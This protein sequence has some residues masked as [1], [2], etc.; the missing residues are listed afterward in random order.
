MSDFP[1]CIKD[2]KV[3]NSKIM[4]ISI[5]EYRCR[6]GCFGGGAAATS[7]PKQVALSK[8]R[9]SSLLILLPAAVLVLLLLSSGIEPNPGPQF[10]CKSCKT[11][12]QQLQNFYKHVSIHK[13]EATIFCPYI[14]CSGH[15]STIRSL[16]SH[17]SRDHKTL[18]RSVSI[19]T[20]QEVKCPILTCGILM[21]TRERYLKHMPHHLKEGISFSC[22]YPN[23]GVHVATLSSFRTHV[24]H[25]HPINGQETQGASCVSSSSS[26]CEASS[27]NDCGKQNLDSEPSTS[28]HDKNKQIQESNTKETAAFNDNNSEDVFYS[29]HAAKAQLAKFY[30]KLEAVHFLPISTVQVIADEIKLV[31]EMSHNFLE[32]CLRSELDSTGLHNSVV[33]EIVNKAFSSDPIYNI[34]HKRQD[35]EQL[36]TDHLRQKFWKKHYPFVQPKEI[37]LGRDVDGSKKLAHYVSIRESIEVMLRDPKIKKMVLDSFENKP[38]ST[39]LSDITD[40]TAF[41]EHKKQHHGGKCIFINLFQD[42]FDYNAFGPSIGVYKPLGFYFAI[43]NLKP[44]YRTK[45]DLI[46]MVYLIMEKH[47]KPSEKEELDDIDKLKEVLRPLIDELE[48]L[49]LNGISVDGEVVPVC[50]LFCQGDN[51]GQHVIGGFVGS[52][53]CQYCCRFCP[54]SLDEFRANPTLTKPLRT[55][56]GYDISVRKAKS[57]WFAFRDKCL[58]TVERRKL[59]RA[60]HAP[61]LERVRAPGTKVT[62]KRILAKSTFEKLRAHNFQGVKYR[63]SALNSEKLGFHVCN[64][65]SLSVCCAH[66]I[67]EGIAKN[68]LPLI[69][70]HF[71]EMGWFDLETLNR[72][73]T[74]FPYEGSDKRDTPTKLKSL[75]ALGGNASENWTLIRLLPFIIGDLIQDREDEMWQLYLKLKLIVEYVFAPKITVIQVLFL[76][77]LIRDYLVEVKRLLPQCL[78][79]KQHLLMHYPELI[80]IYEPLVRLFTLR[81]EKAIIS[82]DRRKVIP[83]EVLSEDSFILL[84]CVTVKGVSYKIGEYMILDSFEE[85]DLQVGLIDNIFLNQSTEEVFFLMNKKPAVNSFQGFFKVVMPANS[86]LFSSLESL[87]DYYPL[88]SYSM[89]GSECINLKHTMIKM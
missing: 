68:M 63:P 12:F 29:E 32:R 38:P 72:G 10:T 34:H 60:R 61:L 2:D 49:K 56:E 82:E 4:G 52:F 47:I 39:I 73:I 70:K 51:L 88:P 30:L 59:E 89:G 75:Q 22:P 33:E 3:A 16:Q 65:P 41:A 79:P 45:I 17:I 44:E 64:G 62:V 54:I 81:F 28:S 48:D 74:T 53:S 11:S 87:P 21:H 71:I 1:E 23:C 80:T 77:S 50:L 15:Y 26:E 8:R 14:D 7:S 40:G 86:Y 84:S 46:Q 9:T 55:P 25:T 57:D 78:W 18:E 27:S 36:G 83:P 20:P 85:C 43:G 69:L 67:F 37:F 6:I 66:D 42:G 24:S 35:A 19:S 5:E 58:Q 13:L 76:K 31:T